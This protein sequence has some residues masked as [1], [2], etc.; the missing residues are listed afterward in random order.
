MLVLEINPIV[1]FVA[2]YLCPVLG[3][4]GEFLYSK[5]LASWPCEN[6]L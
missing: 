3:F 2:N 6:L 5:A 4:L 1:G